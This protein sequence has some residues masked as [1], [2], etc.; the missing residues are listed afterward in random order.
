[1]N[2]QPKVIFKEVQRFGF[3]LRLFIVF[4]MSVAAIANSFGLY[5]ML[6][7]P[8]PSSMLSIALLIIVGILFPAALSILFIM[9]KL[10]TMVRPDG[11]YAR[12]F[13]LHLHF[14]RFSFDDINE[15]FVRTYRP[16]REY[17]GWGIRCGFGDSG[18][19][20]N[21]RGNKGLQL[22]FKN[23]KRLLIG[24]QQPERLVEALNSIQPQ[25]D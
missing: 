11:L 25:N 4:S 16:I 20:Y 5:K 22:V 10:E 3:I 9:L 18:K 14:K 24:S 17:G 1:M 23:G 6:S 2:E 12:Y 21:V 8:Q 15:Y 13:P 19:A 7:E